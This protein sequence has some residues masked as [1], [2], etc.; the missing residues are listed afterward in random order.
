MHGIIYKATGPTG[1]VYVGQ[2]TRTLAMRK[3]QHKFRAL[4][5]DRRSA[6]QIAL[7]D[8]GF[9]NF[10]WEQIDTADSKEELDKKEKLWIAHYKADKP[11]HG[12]NLQD[13][14]IGGTP[15]AE[16]RRKM[17]EAHRGKYPS[18]E[19]RQKLSDVRK[20][21]KH[22]MYGKHHSEETRKKIS[23]AHKGEKNHNYGKQREYLR[24]EKVHTAKI[25]EAIARNIKLDLQ[26]GMRICDLA[27]KHNTNVEVVR[28]IKRGNSWAWVQI[29]DSA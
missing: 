8:E 27:K 12:Y 9:S 13:G 4:K 22:H 5:G 3:G 28:A 10:Q 29:G 17:S 21:E 1:K 25:T 11:E 14:G 6:F 26:T 2:T 23:E 16:A 18:P 19:T 20:G 15:N 24:G 7:L